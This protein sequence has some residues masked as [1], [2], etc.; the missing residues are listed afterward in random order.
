[1]RGRGLVLVGLVV[2]ACAQVGVLG[3]GSAPVLAR[4]SHA[5]ESQITE[6][7]VSSGAAVPGPLR[8]ANSMTVFGGDLFVAEVLAGQVASTNFR[9]DEFGESVP[10]SGG[11]GF[12]SQLP[13]LASPNE[14]LER[15][16]AFGTA[17]GE[18]EMYLG[19]GNS[20]GVAV[21]GLGLCG[22]GV[23]ECASLQER[24]TGADAP[25]GSFG[26]KVSVATDDST[27]GEDWAKGD[28]FVVAGS[29][30][31]EP[32][33]V[34]VFKPEAG[35]KEKY[36][37]QITGTSPGSPFESPGL[38]AV[39]GLNGDVI[40]AERESSV[41]LFKPE[42]VGGKQT[43]SFVG[44]LVPSGGFPEHESIAGVAVDNSNGEI[45][46][47]TRSV[48]YEFNKFGVFVGEITGES[49][50]EKEWSSRNEIESIAVDPV[51]H[52]VFVGVFDVTLES[53]V[54]DVFGR[55][56]VI[57]DVESEE[58]SN[59]RLEAG[60]HTWGVRLNGTVDADE[61]GPARCWF[62]WGTSRS[63]GQESA[64]TG[65]VKGEVD[66]EAVS[67]RANLSGLEPGTT[68]YYRLQAENAT[69]KNLGE[70][71][72]DQSFTTPGPGLHGEWA[73]EVSS[74]SVRLHATIAPEDKPTSYHFEYDA[75][76]YVQGEAPHGT[77]VPLTGASAGSSGEAAVEQHVE[78]LTASTAYHYRVVALSEVEVSSGVFAQEEFDGPDQVFTTQRAGGAL[79]LAD[80]RAWEQV[81]S[82]DKHGA[83]IRPIAELG[84]VQ[85]SAD[86]SK[87]T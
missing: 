37:T 55:D 40:V 65:E 64:C 56:V 48:V 22:A 86:G 76:P 24:W 75:S 66:E 12:V 42:E 6:V 73:T 19:K 35:G 31:G 57:P 10:G 52:R 58:V 3:L 70:E 7:P 71:S 54:V 5:F 68:Y 18:T 49:T 20:G 84:L 45:Y 38:V 23:L 80:G 16:I 11:Y 62:V 26:Q 32:R 79:V 41:D 33:A 82:V 28:V 4:T 87:F 44:Q 51:S 74:S 39:S 67:V 34:D 29:E 2:G 47:A 85:S 63:F 13:K 72:Q 30:P 61:A 25:G 15:G 8:E 43:Y 53:G 27:S 46:V 9:V 50:P 77:S 1:M 81:S 60:S 78:G 83:V 17:T 69:G 21:F 36:V 14:S 59:V